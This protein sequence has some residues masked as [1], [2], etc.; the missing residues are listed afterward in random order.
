VNDGVEIHP[1]APQLASSHAM[2]RSSRLPKPSGRTAILTL[3]G[4]RRS[5]SRTVCCAAF[6]E[7]LAEKDLACCRRGLPLSQISARDFDI[8]VVGQLLTANL[9]L[10]DEFG[11]GPVKRRLPGIVPV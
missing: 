4:N 11:Q 5:A 8:A 7:Q 10:G 2:I 9:P 1:S 3:T 6:I